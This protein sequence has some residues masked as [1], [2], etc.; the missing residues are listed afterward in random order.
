MNDILGGAQPERRGRSAA[1]TP[2]E[3][4]S[5]N[6]VPAS[7]GARALRRAP[8]RGLSGEHRTIPLTIRLS[9]TSDAL[10][11]GRL[12]QLDGALYDGTPALVAE[13][14]GRLVA[15]LP[16]DGSHPFSDPF[17]RTAQALAMLQLRRE[18]LVR[19]QRSPR[20]AG[21]LRRR[22]RAQASG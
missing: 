11:L 18:Q 12:A 16:L 2:W 22:L 19:A 21:R 8:E 14:D 13:V 1:G 7:T 15:A 9:R 3:E 17:E 4:R 20:R 5:R 6:A 10:A